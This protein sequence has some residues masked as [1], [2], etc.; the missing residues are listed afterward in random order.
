MRSMLQRKLSSS[1]MTWTTGPQEQDVVV[2]VDDPRHHGAPAQ[3]DGPR[4]IAVVVA[5]AVTHGGE[6]AVLDQHGGH[7]LVARVHRMDP[8]VDEPERAALLA[9]PVV[10]P[11]GQ[12][13]E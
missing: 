2:A 4:A 13:D 12:R 9:V 10:G 1:S 11:S 5:A 6:P 3:V 8:A 7:D